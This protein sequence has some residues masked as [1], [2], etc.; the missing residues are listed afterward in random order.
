MTM[1]SFLN[2]SI[3]IIMGFCYKGNPMVYFKSLRQRGDRRW[4]VENQL[5]KEEGRV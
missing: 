1:E 5:V 2:R 4:T 3:D